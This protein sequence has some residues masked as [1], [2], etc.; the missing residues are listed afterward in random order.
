MCVC[1]CVCVCACVYVCEQKVVKLLTEI[2][3]V[4]QQEK[5]VQGLLDSG[6]WCTLVCVC[7]C[8]CVYVFLNSVSKSCRRFSI[9]G[10]RA[11][12]MHACCSRTAKFQMLGRNSQPFPSKPLPLPLSLPFVVL[13]FLHSWLVQ[14]SEKTI[15]ERVLSNTCCCV[16]NL[17]RH[18]LR[19]QPKRTFHASILM[20][21][22]DCLS[23]NFGFSVISLGAA[24]MLGE[25]LKKLFM[26]AVETYCKEV[27]LKFVRTHHAIHDTRIVH[28]WRWPIVAVGCRP[29]LSQP[30]WN[31]PS[32]ILCAVNHIECSF[33]GIFSL[34][35]KDLNPQIDP[36]R[37]RAC[38][39]AVCALLCDMLFSAYKMRLALLD[40]ASAQE[41]ADKEKEAKAKSAN[42]TEEKSK[43]KSKD[44]DKEKDGDKDKAKEP[45]EG[46][47]IAQFLKLSS[48]QIHQATRA[49]SSYC[50]FVPPH[51]F[52]VWKCNVGSSNVVNSND[53]TSRVDVRKRSAYHRFNE[54]RR[55][56]AT[57]HY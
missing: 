30:T 34:R 28:A 41:K 16:V 52:F 19:K 38:Y 14:R 1:V 37:F 51:F 5:K 7:M 26:D 57:S 20:A 35:C 40:I 22:L 15:K 55:I 29:F 21:R 9:R 50:T 31:T 39:T 49:A 13:T 3:Y 10:W 8:V 24:N 6:A 53:A 33:C 56:L 43:D 42:A 45:S 17:M 36:T 27:V 4:L 54:R 12:W 46:A 25:D 44:K 18:N 32:K 23:L 11:P 47:K 48:D 2:R